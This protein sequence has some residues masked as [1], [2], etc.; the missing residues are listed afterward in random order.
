MNAT[1]QRISEC[2]RHRSPP[3]SARPNA[4]RAFTLIELLVVIAVIAILAALI[5]PALSAAKR[6]ARNVVCQSNQKQLLLEFLLRREDASMRLDTVMIGEWF[7]NVFFGP[8]NSGCSLC[9]EAPLNPGMG[10]VVSPGWRFGDVGSAWIRYNW[11][12]T[13]SSTKL[14]TRA[15]SY[16]CNMWMVAPA[17]S[18]TYPGGFNQMNWSWVSGGDPR[19]YPSESLVTHADR[20]PLLADGVA[21]AVT[22]YPTN[23]PATD[24]V[25]GQLGDMS[26]M[27]IPRH[28]ARP[29]PVPTFWPVTQPL[30]GAVNVALYDGH[31]EPLKLDRL[32]QLYWTSDWVPPAKRPGL[33]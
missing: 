16:A 23:L 19:C 14:E 10:V 1:E 24:L 13:T 32:W 3:L 21:Y 27:T 12:P 22:P 2:G 5:L 25:T 11:A 17:W 8:T 15:S 26:S 31:V 6:K 4:R 18:A 20:T 33:P 29:K 7:G 28:G 30:P 9:P